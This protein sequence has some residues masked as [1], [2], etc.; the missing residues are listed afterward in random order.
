MADILRLAIDA[1]DSLGYEIVFA[2]SNN[3]YGYRDLEG[4]RE[5]LGFVPQD[6]D[7]AAFE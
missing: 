4:A 7:E 2:T 6:T 5:A 3:R 1:P